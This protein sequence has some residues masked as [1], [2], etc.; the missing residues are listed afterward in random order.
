MDEIKT[1]L[2]TVICAAL[3][4]A[5]TCTVMASKGVNGALVR[6]LAGVIMTVTLITPFKRLD[7][8]GINGYWDAYSSDAASSVALGVEQTK[9]ALRDGI[10]KRS[11]EYIL[12]EASRLN[13][14]ITAA[15]QL[16]DDDLPVPVRVDL[17]GNAS[18]YAKNALIQSVCTAFDLKK[19]NVQWT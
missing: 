1:Y 15:V 4:C 16:S 13:L 3:I 8:S 10:K 12:K 6:L 18:P 9:L 7:L 17:S 19:E 14:S 2:M 5:I 11:E